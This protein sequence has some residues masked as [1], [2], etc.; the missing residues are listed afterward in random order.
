[1]ASSNMSTDSA[2]GLRESDEDRAAR[3]V[4]ALCERLSE[5]LPQNQF[6]VTVEH[7]HAIRIV[8]IDSRQGDT[9]W[10]SPMPLWRSRSPIE[11]RLQLFLDEA[12]RG[13]QKFVS[14][15]NRP[16]PSR[17]AKPNVSIGEESI[18]IW[19]GGSNMAEAALALRPITRDELGV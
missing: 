18:L 15:R 10:L 5:V 1:M 4:A 12:S 16:W 3:L 9:L 13:V 14:R 19:W 6:E 11:H 17:S 2:Q 8:G 7:C